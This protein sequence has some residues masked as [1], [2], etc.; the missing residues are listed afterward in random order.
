[1]ELISLGTGLGTL[2]II[3]YGL[4]HPF[5]IYELNYLYG[6]WSLL[7]VQIVVFVTFVGHCINLPLANA[8]IV[9]RMNK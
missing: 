4:N 1:M 5:E 3:K 6:S 9:V 7:L 2:V 8:K